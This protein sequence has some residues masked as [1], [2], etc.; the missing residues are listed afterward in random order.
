[1]VGVVEVVL[2]DERFGEEDEVLKFRHDFEPVVDVFCGLQS[3]V[4]VFD[5]E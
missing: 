4:G 3:S 5:L 1:L 2:L